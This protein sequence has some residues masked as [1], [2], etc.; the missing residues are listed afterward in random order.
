MYKEETGNGKL[1][2]WDAFAFTNTHMAVPRLRV[3]ACASQ[4]VTINRERTIAYYM[5]RVEFTLS[6]E[7]DT[8]VPCGAHRNAFLHSLNYS[9]RMMQRAL[10]ITDAKTRVFFHRPPPAFVATYNTCKRVSI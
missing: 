9:I 5:R 6:D 3:R 7:T 2:G 8:R 1:L 10:S 4:R